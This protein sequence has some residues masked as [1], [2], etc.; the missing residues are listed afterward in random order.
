ML[1]DIKKA[2]TW[3]FAQR[4]EYVI[5]LVCFWKSRCEAFLVGTGIEECVAKPY[6]KVTDAVQMAPENRKCQDRL[7]KGK[8]KENAET[9]TVSSSKGQGAAT[10]ADATS[11]SVVGER[12]RLAGEA[13][14]VGVH[15]D[16]TSQTTGRLAGELALHKL[17]SCISCSVP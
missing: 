13:S 17:A 7:E 16:T 9:K 11:I 10:G 8:A 14:T 12:V 6:Q 4:M 2:R 5:K 1:K 3:T 15:Q